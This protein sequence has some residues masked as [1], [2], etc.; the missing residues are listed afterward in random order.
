V[1][2][3]ICDKLILL[4]LFRPLESFLP[5]MTRR[6]LVRCSQNSV[7]VNYSIHINNFRKRKAYLNPLASSWAVIRL[8]KITNQYSADNMP[9]VSFMWA[10]LL[11]ISRHHSSPSVYVLRRAC[12]LRCTA[13]SLREVS[14]V[15]PRNFKHSRLPTRPEKW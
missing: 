5:Q 2:K 15:V 12:P 9:H 14:I 11:V 7:D 4:R 13:R 6:T 1:R 10:L 8:D 3:E